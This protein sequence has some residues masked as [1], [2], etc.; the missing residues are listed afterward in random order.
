MQ[1]N[2]QIVRELYAAAE[3]PGINAA[4]FTA[5]FSEAGY[6]RDMPSGREF[7]GEDIGK[8][9]A[10]FGSAFPDVHRELL[11]TCV[12]EN[13]VVV[14]LAIRGTHTGDLQLPSGVLAPTRKTIDVPCCDVFYLENGKVAAFHCYKI[15]SVMLQ[16]LGV[17]TD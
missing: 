5:M 2:E 17:G 9:I 11:T 4:K 12:A 8:S 15:D 6:M 1:N 16:Q 3:G 13:V 14:E 7:R 10:G